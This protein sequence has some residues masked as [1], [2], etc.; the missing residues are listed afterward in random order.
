[1]KMF[2]EVVALLTLLTFLNDPKTMSSY[3]PVAPREMVLHLLYISHT[4]PPSLM[5]ILYHLI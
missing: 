2:D 4:Y 1:M 3:P 5:L